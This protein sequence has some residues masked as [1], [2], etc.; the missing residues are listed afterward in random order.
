MLSDCNRESRAIS[1]DAGLQRAPGIEGGPCD[2]P[3]PGEPHR[4][5]LDDRRDLHDRDGALTAAHPS[6][7]DAD[8]EPGVGLGALLSGPVPTGII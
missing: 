5:G 8:P 1:D 4:A 3:R 2:V 6:C 7:G